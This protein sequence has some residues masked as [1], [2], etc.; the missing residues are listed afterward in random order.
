MDISYKQKQY[1]D[2]KQPLL[3][4]LIVT[5][6]PHHIAMNISVWYHFRQLFQDLAVGLHNLL[7]RMSAWDIPGSFCGFKVM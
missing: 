7:L 6:M 1:E 5:S 2:I 4:G 3:L